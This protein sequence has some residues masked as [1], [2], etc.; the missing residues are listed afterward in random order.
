MS[1]ELYHLHTRSIATEKKIR[2]ESSENKCVHQQTPCQSADDM[3][4]AEVQTRTPLPLYTEP[5]T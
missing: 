5:V 2:E 3:G 1:L 4:I